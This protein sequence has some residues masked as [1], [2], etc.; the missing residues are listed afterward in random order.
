M[1]EKLTNYMIFAKKYFFATCCPDS[2]AYAD[3]KQPSVD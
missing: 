1:Y 3:V 2:Y